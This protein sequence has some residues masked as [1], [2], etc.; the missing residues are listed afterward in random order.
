[1]TSAQTA[2]YR[3]RCLHGEKG[4]LTPP[5]PVRLVGQP[6]RGKH[7]ATRAQLPDV[8]QNMVTPGQ[9]LKR[10]GPSTSSSPEA[11]VTAEISDEPLSTYEH[12]RLV[13]TLENT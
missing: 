11:P 9:P 13:R 1:M 3:K 5:S 8:T 12:E 2:A 4:A 6:K 7:S 10:E